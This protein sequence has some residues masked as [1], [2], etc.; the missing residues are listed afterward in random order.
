MQLYI[1]ASRI[2]L[3]AKLSRIAAHISRAVE[4]PAGGCLPPTEAESLDF[5]REGAWYDF[6][7]FFYFEVV[8]LRKG[9][10]LALIHSTHSHLFSQI[11]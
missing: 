2:R 4:L 6:F 9:H 11:S 7:F 1:N 3:T 10:F 8:E 5:W